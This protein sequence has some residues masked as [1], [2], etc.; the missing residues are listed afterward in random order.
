MKNFLAITVLLL[1]TMPYLFA[2]NG[3]KKQEQQEQDKQEISK[4]KVNGEI[5]EDDF[6]DSIWDQLWQRVFGDKENEANYTKLKERFEQKIKA[7]ARVR[8]ELERKSKALNRAK[9]NVVLQRDT[10]QNQQEQITRQGLRI[11]TLE[12]VVETL[13]TEV[14]DLT[15]ERDS[16]QGLLDQ[17]QK[18]VTLKNDTISMLRADTAALHLSLDSFQNEYDSLNIR[19]MKSTFKVI[20]INEKKSGVS[21]FQIDL[22]Q[23]NETPHRCV[24][25]I[26]FSMEAGGKLGKE[27]NGI[28]A[29]LCYKNK[30]NKLIE[31]HEKD[32]VSINNGFIKGNPGKKFDYHPDSQKK[33]KKRIKAGKYTL[34]IKIGNDQLLDKQLVAIKAAKGDLN[35]PTTNICECL[36]KA[37]KRLLEADKQSDV[38]PVEEFF[39]F[40]REFELF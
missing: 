38:K 29:T 40:Q 9:S 28:M 31:I 23:S 27:A 10:I 24:D 39:L 22:I 3:A 15:A 13:R 12:T 20:G 16:L 32:N 34:F 6:D 26:R 8:E 33:K 21:K 14:H 17:C 35:A 37:K 36:S 4:E 30:Q 25:R 2:Q 7:L 5:Q 11:T 18:T 19:F 1:I